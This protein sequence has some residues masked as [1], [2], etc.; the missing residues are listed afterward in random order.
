[1][2]NNK[3]E[4][5]SGAKL[6]VK[7]LVSQANSVAVALIKRGITKSDKICIFSL[8]DINYTVI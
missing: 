8:I 4:A 7:E 5:E 1:M 2:C 6:T 3:I